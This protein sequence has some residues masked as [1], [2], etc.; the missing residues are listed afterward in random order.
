LGEGDDDDVVADFAYFRENVEAVGCAIAN[1]IEVEKD[2][3]EIGEFEDGFD[4]V[5]GGGEGSTELSTEVL[6]DFGEKLVVV[7]DDGESVA[8]RAGG[9]FGQAS[10]FGC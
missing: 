10:G 9:W 7:G 6:A 3:V 2:G 8:L 4:F 5:N 1:A